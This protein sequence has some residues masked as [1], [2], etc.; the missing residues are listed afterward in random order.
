MH[1]IRNRLEEIWATLEIAEEL[2]MV[3]EREK[4]SEI[5]L[6]AILTRPRLQAPWEIKTETIIILP[7]VQTPWA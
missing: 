6:W 5:Y 1:S 4:V 2:I 7:W 3:E